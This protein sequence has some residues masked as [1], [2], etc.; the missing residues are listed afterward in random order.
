MSVKL[1]IVMLCG[2]MFVLWLSH[3]HL[4]EFRNRNVLVSDR[5]KVVEFVSDFQE[6]RISMLQQELKL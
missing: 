1:K 3:D 4:C 2:I 6:Y 5:C